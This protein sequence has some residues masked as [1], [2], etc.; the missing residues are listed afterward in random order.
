MTKGIFII[1]SILGISILL[2]ILVAMIA[3]FQFNRSVHR[4]IE[5]FYS[6]IENN[7]EVIQRSDLEGLPLPVQNWLIYSQVVGKEKI[8]SARTKQDV[9]MRLK[10]EQSWMNAQVEQYF[11]TEEPGFIWAVDIKMAPLVHIVGRDKYIDGRGNMFIKVLS[12]ITVANGSGKEIDQGTLLRYLAETIWL[13][14][15]ALSDLIS[16]EAIDSK[17]AKATMSYKGVTASGIFTFN[18]KGE[19]INFVAQRYGDFDGEYRMETW[20]VDMKSYKEFSGFKVPTEGKLTWKLTTGDFHWYNFDV[21]ELEYNTP[22]R[23]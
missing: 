13:P 15:E 19:V 20:S 7:H 4:E 12:L 21:R 2:V 10:A 14:T 18:E 23:Y 16:W 17:S 3:N 8:V 1:L 11:R 22:V 5:T 9:T 6:S